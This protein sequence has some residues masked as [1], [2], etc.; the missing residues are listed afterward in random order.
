MLSVKHHCDVIMMKRTQIQL[1]EEQHRKLK[2]WSDRL[3]IS[4]AEAVRRCVDERLQAEEAGL[5][6]E[7]LVREAVAVVGKYA[8]PEGRICVGRDHGAWLAEAYRE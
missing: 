1:T 2:R 8:D 3:G 5:G 7:Q 4:M 6:R